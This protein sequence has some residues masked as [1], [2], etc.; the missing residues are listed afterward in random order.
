[1]KLIKRIAE[2]LYFKCYPE[3]KNEH[4]IAWQPIP[5]IRESRANIVKFTAQVNLPMAAI[6]Q[7]KIPSEWIR[8]ELSEKLRRIIEPEIEIRS[9]RDLYS[10]RVIYTG[11]IRVL[12]RD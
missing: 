9:E 6:A 8:A 2:A 11:I 7:D 3:R 4:E 1:M 5:I 12:R 10:N